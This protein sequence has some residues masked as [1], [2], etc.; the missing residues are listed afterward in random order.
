LEIKESNNK[1]IKPTKYNKKFLEFINDDLNT[2]RALALMWDLI[3]D[4]KI[5]SKDKYES[6]LEFDKIFALNLSQIKETK[7]PANI[8][9]LAQEREKYRKEKNWKKSDELRK[10]IEKQG[11]Q[12]EDTDQGP[13]IKK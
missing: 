12:I 2:P 8:K 9:K 10:K 6:L 4:E 7:I 3:K 13:K 1:G 11:F 5:S